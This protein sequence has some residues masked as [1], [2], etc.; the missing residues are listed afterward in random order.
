MELTFDGTTV[1]LRSLEWGDTKNVQPSR[2]ARIAG[3]TVKA[4]HREHPV[5]RF[6][7][8]TSRGNCLNEI[9]DFL[10][11]TIGDT[12]DI[13]GDNFIVHESASITEDTTGYS[14]TFVLEKI[15]S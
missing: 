3:N 15:C 11:L 9:E 8:G 4:L 14:V 10:A 1:E 6:Y 5:S 12:I 13:D 2:I 7:T